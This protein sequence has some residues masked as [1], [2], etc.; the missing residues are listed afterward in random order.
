LKSGGLYCYSQRLGFRWASSS[1]S[2]EAI[3]GFIL[4]ILHKKKRPVYV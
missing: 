1:I 2:G 4:N 3:V